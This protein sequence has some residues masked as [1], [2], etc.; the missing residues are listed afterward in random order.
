MNQYQQNYIDIEKERTSN[1]NIIKKHNEKIMTTLNKSN[2]QSLVIIES[3]TPTKTLE[4]QLELKQLEFEK[5]KQ[6]LDNIS[7][8]MNDE[9]NTKNQT[10]N[11]LKELS[12]KN[13]DQIDEFEEN[14]VEYIEYIQII[15]SECTKEISNLTNNYKDIISKIMD[16]KHNSDEQ[17]ICNVN[18]IKTLNELVN[19]VKN[20]KINLNKN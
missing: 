12:F 3:I 7:S 19:K 14:L 20:D 2:S 18:E 1:L 15:L 4:I 16:Y 9:I 13:L 8:L 17:L 6:S 5:V 11:K 10:I